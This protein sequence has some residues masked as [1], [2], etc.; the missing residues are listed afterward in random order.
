M[1]APVWAF[2]KKEKLVGDSEIVSS[3]Y[4]EELVPLTLC[5]IDLVV[6]F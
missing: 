5:L 1:E 4:I 3:A 6:S 2:E